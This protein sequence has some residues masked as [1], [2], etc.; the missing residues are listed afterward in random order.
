MARQADVKDRCL[1]LY[2]YIP[3]GFE[4]ML[5]HHPGVIDEYLDMRAEAS[6]GATPGS[7]SERERYLVLLALEI[8]YGKVP[9][10]H[11]K[12]FIGAGGS[13]DEVA[14]LVALCICLRGM[15]TNQMTGH[16]AIEV[17]ERAEAE[18]EAGTSGET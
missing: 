10:G 6:K 4:P 3:A 16:E 13:A 1:E 12:G 18:A 7:L 9:E 11:I 17:A 5:R 2:G 15:M 14:E 8:P